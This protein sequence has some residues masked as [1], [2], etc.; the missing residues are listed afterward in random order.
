M[1]FTI[2][3]LYLLQLFNDS[4]DDF[5]F[6]PLPVLEGENREIVLQRFVKKGYEDLTAMGLIVDGLPTEECIEF[7]FYL[8]EYQD[9]YYHYQI[10][11][12][13]FCAPAVDEFDRMTVVI[14]KDDEGLYFVQRLASVLFV[15]ILLQTHPVLHFL[16]DR[17]KD[18]LH[19]LYEN[20]PLLSLLTYS[21]KEEALRIAV[22]EY[23]KQSSD[24]V[25]Y[26]QGGSLYEYDL[27]QQ[28]RRSIDG[29]GLR[30]LIIKKLRVEV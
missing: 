17:E 22:Q 21:R 30:Q 14:R 7:G 24:F 1:K 3:A 20:E 13:Y 29:E 16:D 6:L 9:S 4:S 12:D 26:T 25:Y 2:E 10:D 15:S 27:S 8:K 19:S 23:G 5:A 11:Q 18:Y 28:M